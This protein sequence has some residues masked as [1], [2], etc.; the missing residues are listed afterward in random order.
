MTYV[1]STEINIAV[2]VI[3]IK[4]PMIILLGHTEYMKSL[5]FY[6]PDLTFNEI[7]TPN[8]VNRSDTHKI[9]SLYVTLIITQ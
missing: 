2:K 8:N 4:A 9:I 7:H 6:Y 1:E 3:T 5:W